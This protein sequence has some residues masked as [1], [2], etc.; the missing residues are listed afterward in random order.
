MTSA[1]VAPIL[2]PQPESG[3]V[4]SIK[5]RRTQ[6]LVLALVGPVGAGVTK[7]ATILSDIFKR[8][9][10]YTVHDVHV[11]NFIGQSA[12]LVG[13][14][15]PAGQSRAEHIRLYQD[16]GTALRAEFGEA[17][18]ADKS[19]E[20][21]AVDRTSDGYDKSGSGAAVPL[22]RRRVH[23]IDSLKNPGELN[24]LR[25]VYGDILWVFGIFAPESV[26]QKRL[27]DDGL[28]DVEAMEIIKIDE[29]EGVDHGQRVSETMHHADFFVRNDKDNDVRLREVLD[30][31]VDLIFGIAVH[32]PT[33]DE[34]AMYEAS[35]AS[36]RSAC[37]SRQVGA[38]IYSGSG[39]LI[40]MGD[41]DV[42]KY[43]GGLYTEDDG[44]GDHRCY[45]WL[46]KL[47][48][49]DQQKDE[50][51]AAIHRELKCAGLLTK[52]GTV[53]QVILAVKKTD[54]KNLIEYSRAVHAEMEA[55]VS[56]A[57]G[58][59]VGI[60]GAT[61][62]TTTY[63]CHNCARH[64]VAS[65][66]SRVVYIEPYVKSKAKT[67]H[68][69]SIS[70]TET[71]D[72]K[73]VFFLQYEGVAPKDMIKLFR[74]RPESPRKKFGMAIKR[75]STNADP[76]FAANLDGF[77]RREQLVAK[78][79]AD[80]EDKARSSAKNLGSADEKGK[81]DGGATK[82]PFSPEPGDDTGPGAA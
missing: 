6:E 80:A 67:L 52:K 33:Q 15:V 34:S 45:K 7:T 49:N 61:M 53:D 77:D 47:C 26:R 38:V 4:P 79:V 70:D 78:Q 27:K 13:K 54:A 10:A 9:Y 29:E 11:S 75:E 41:N 17:Y 48:H 76:T 28:K 31:Y 12:S 19:I 36:S 50:L 66:I 18:L 32:T 1:S 73:K 2:E 72:D 57:R 56:V 43:G 44:D 68:S 30:R 46:R 35:S 40:G 58:H 20:Q 55:I 60:V 62:Y 82:L 37:L 22:P 42:P 39:E 25:E 16:I 51:Y 69:D 14:R 59:K 8:R 74:L 71:K 5:D 23:I 21:I 3:K 24:R 63:P 64:I 81:Q 65:G